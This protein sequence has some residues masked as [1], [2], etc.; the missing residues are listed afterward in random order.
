MPNSSQSFINAGFAIFASVLLLVGY[1]QSIK[2]LDKTCCVQKTSQ[3]KDSVNLVAKIIESDLNS[4]VSDIHSLSNS[5]ALERF[6]KN[7]KQWSAQFYEDILKWAQTHPKYFQIRILDK[8]GMELYRLDRDSANRF[9]QTPYAQLQNKNDR[10]YV[11]KGKQ[12]KP[13][14]IYLSELDL[15]V[16]NKQIS[17]PLQP[18]LR[19]VKG[20]YDKNKQ[21]IAM[22]VLNYDANYLFEKFKVLSSTDIS[23]L[24]A[25]GFWLYSP[26]KE[27]NWGFMFGALHQRFANESPEAWKKIIEKEAGKIEVNSDVWIYKKIYPLRKVKIGIDDTIEQS[28][29]RGENDYHWILISRQNIKESETFALKQEFLFWFTLIFVLVFLIVIFLFIRSYQ[30]RRAFTKGSDKLNL[31]DLDEADK[32]YEFGYQEALNY[33]VDQD[34]QA[35]LVFKH[36][37]VVQYNSLAFVWLGSKPLE[38]SRLTEIDAIQNGENLSHAIKYLDKQHHI[39]T[40]VVL[41]TFNSN[42]HNTCVNVFGSKDSYVML[43]SRDSSEKSS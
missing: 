1:Y 34:H 33:F 9:F 13:E 21:L 25:D 11:V 17:Q 18:T 23:L 30:T 8:T 15:N 19:V 5:M 35:M 40:H 7:P 26:I 14:Q 6:K 3:A 37:K 24:N 39:K 31:K 36:G 2:I 29:M 43:L 4:L 16:E 38:N 20:M 41:K 10:Y 32:G 28:L 42:E 27:K 12:L 22:I